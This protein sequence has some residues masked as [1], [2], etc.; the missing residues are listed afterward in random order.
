MIH[1]RRGA[2]VEGIGSAAD[3][4]RNEKNFFW[5]LPRRWNVRCS[6]R[7]VRT[8]ADL[9]HTGNLFQDLNLSFQIFTS[10]NGL[11]VRAM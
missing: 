2:Q 6:A 9:K 1:A 4:F 3:W 11:A 7:G 5:N 8:S 10:G